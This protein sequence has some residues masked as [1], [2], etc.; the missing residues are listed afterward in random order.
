MN[1]SNEARVYTGTEIAGFM[2]RGAW[3]GARVLGAAVAFLATVWAI[4]T[5]LPDEARQGVN[6]AREA[7]AAPGS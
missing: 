2:L 5:L 4:G 7:A 3:L 6:A 1:R